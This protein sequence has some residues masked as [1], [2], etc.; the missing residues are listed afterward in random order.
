MVPGEDGDPVALRDALLGEGVGELVRALLDLGEC[1]LTELVDDHRLV[2]IAD[3]SGGDAGSRR[4][5]PA[6][7]LAKDL[8]QPIGTSRAN[9]ARIDEDLDVE[10]DVGQQAQRAHLHLSQALLD[11]ARNLIPR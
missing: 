11:H 7:E 8:G 10:G 6:P 4:G 3:R 5:A 9:D 2:R 1:E